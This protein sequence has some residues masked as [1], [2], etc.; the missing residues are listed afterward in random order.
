[1]WSKFCK[2]LLTRVL[3]WEIDG[4]AAPERECVILGVPHTSIADFFVSYLFYTGIGHTAHIM[5]KKEFF[6]WPAGPI[7]RK[8][9]C[10]P[11]DRSNGATVVRSVISEMEKAKGEFHLCV[12]PEGTRKPVHRWKTGYH[13]IASAMHCPVYLG[14]FNW[15]TKHISIGPRFDIGDNAREDTEKIQQIYESMNLGAKH[16]EKYLTH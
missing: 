6:F 9:G 16:P 4:D 2:W 3:G 5:I 8:V 15:R 14:Y 10:I 12:A 7:L 11:V 13:L 1:M